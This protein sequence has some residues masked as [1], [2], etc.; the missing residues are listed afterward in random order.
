MKN[1]FVYVSMYGLTAG[2]F[3]KMGKSSN[4]LWEIG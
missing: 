1:N 4:K 3:L 2:F